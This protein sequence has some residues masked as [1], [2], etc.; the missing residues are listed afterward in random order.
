LDILKTARITKLM[1]QSQ[2][3]KEEDHDADETNRRGNEN[4]TQSPNTIV[5][6]GASLFLQMHVTGSNQCA[7]DSSTM[8]REKIFC[9]ST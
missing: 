5:P 8:T 7:Q 9:I 4:L 1:R 6:I 2:V 3:E